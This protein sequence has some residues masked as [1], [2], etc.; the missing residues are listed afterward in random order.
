M[1]ATERALIE[2]LFTQVGA[3]LFEAARKLNEIGRIE[4]NEPSPPPAQAANKLRVRPARRRPDSTRG[5]IRSAIAE[6]PSDNSFGIEDLERLTSVPPA[7]VR[8]H[9]AVLRKLGEVERLTRGVYRKT[10]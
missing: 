8:A 10:V 5:R 2:D 9:L 3:Q 6:L 4:G 1:H 7:E